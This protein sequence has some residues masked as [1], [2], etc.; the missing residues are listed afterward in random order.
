M[1]FEQAEK[2][3]GPRLESN[4]QSLEC[5]PNALSTELRG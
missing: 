5:L 1:T 4:L 2:Y 3:A